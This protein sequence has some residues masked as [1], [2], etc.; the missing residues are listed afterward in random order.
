MID[1]V[2]KIY[3]IRCKENKKMYIGRT[4]QEI[5]ERIKAHLQLLRR[6]KHSS[7]LMQ[8][9]FN[10]FGEDSFEFYELESGLTF[11]DRDREH[12]FMD[13]YKSCNSEYGYN[14][15]DQHSRKKKIKI[16]KGHPEA[17]K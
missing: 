2:Y 13:M 8:E 6:C 17:P 11:Q 14:V 3:A 1:D 5:E 10:K 9:D 15:R 4:K 12:F 7:K 16:I